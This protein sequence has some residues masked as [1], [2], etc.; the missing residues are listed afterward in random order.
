[1]IHYAFTEKGEAEI[2]CTVKGEIVCPVS[3]SHLADI[4]KKSVDFEQKTLVLD[5]S[6]VKLI[7]SAGIGKLFIE[8]QKLSQNG[9]SLKISSCP[10]SI[11][12]I[13]NIVKA[14]KYF[15]VEKLN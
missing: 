1:M 5:F 12:S 15:S 7:N 8:N 13:L 9:R 6:G 4:F 11:Y 2:E 14:Q 10:E 3:V